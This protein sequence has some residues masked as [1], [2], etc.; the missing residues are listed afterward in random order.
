MPGWRW[1]DEQVVIWVRLVEIW[2]VWSRGLAREDGGPVGLLK[3]PQLDSLPRHLLPGQ[4][5]PLGRWV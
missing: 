5:V 2:R 1:V 3:R 4:T